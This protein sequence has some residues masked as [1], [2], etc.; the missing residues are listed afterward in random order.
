MFSADAHAR[1]LALGASSRELVC[2]HDGKRFRYATRAEAA[3]LAEDLAVAAL[4][5]FLISLTASLPTI[6]AAARGARR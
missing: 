5:R 3:A 6:R 2:V 4:E 1:A